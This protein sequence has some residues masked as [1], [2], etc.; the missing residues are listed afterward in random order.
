MERLSTCMSERNWHMDAA[1]TSTSEQHLL[2]QVVLG[3]RIH[4]FAL[5]CPFFIKI[6][7]E[8]CLHP[9]FHL[10]K[11]LCDTTVLLTWK[12]CPCM[13]KIAC[14]L[15]VNSCIQVVQCGYFRLEG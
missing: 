10:Y 13:S 15:L 9:S 6:V 2:E 1:E 7:T 12:E 4:I 3:I 11:L 5:V 8:S 14:L